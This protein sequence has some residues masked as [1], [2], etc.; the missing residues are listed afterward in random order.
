[1]AKPRRQRV[2]A[3]LA[4]M[5]LA[6]TLAACAVDN[7]QVGS[8]PNKPSSAAVAPENP[9]TDPSKLAIA[10]NTLP[11]YVPPTT[12]RDG[13]FTKPWLNTNQQYTWSIFDQSNK[14]LTDY[15]P[16]QTIAWGSPDT[17]TT[18]PGVLVFRG[19]QARTAPSYGTADIT[20][21]KLSI[22]WTQDIGEV[23][24]DGSVWPGAGWTGQPLLVNW[25]EATRK[26]MGFAPEF[27]NKNLTEV[28]YPTFDGHIYRMDLET[29]KATKAPIDSTWGFK[30]TGSI[31]P[32]GYPLLYTGQGLND[33]NGEIGPW[34]YRIYDLIQNKEVSGWSGTDPVSSRQEWGAFDSSGLVNRQTD[35]LIEPG[36]NGLIYKVKLNAQFNPTTRKVSVN[37]QIVKMNFSTPVSAKHGVE[38]SAVAYRN[39]MYATDNDGNLICW[40][41]NTL[42]VV[43]AANVQDD[44][45][46]TMTIDETEDGVFLYTGN[47]VDKRG[48]TTD[49]VT[50]LR[51]FDALTGKQVWQYDIP[52]QYNPNVNGGTMASPLNGKGEISDLIIYS[53]A[54]TTSDKEGTLV[55]LDK[56][57]GKV[58]WERHMAAYGWSSPVSITGTDGHQYG[59]ICDYAGLMHLF[60]PNTGQD[61]AT[62]SLGKNVEASPSVYNNMI[63][64]ASY[65]KKIF[66]IK[67]S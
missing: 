9:E 15:K 61:Y 62:V 37:P 40:D 27:A 4:T 32:R 42:E 17:Y 56:K 11:G 52:T 13:V 21:K 24:G 60:D 54:K 1:M 14:L 6:A 8:R 12:A 33:R 51:K 10:L 48:T 43:W 28:I 46:A 7:V 39:L 19:N 53:V 59:I 29:G 5:G 44:S 18:V 65:A 58:V 26:A 57:T 34:R 64:V 23:S 38:N 20:E 31:D 36:E 35:T 3:A 47:E 49:K 67:V 2:V 41:A 66:A 45:D 55:A 16:S 25:P 30:G 50:Q 63:V 22:V